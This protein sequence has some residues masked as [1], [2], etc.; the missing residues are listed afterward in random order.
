MIYV[1]DPLPL[2]YSMA[3]G[4]VLDLEIF[5]NPVEPYTVYYVGEYPPPHF[6][7][8]NYSVVE[9]DRGKPCYGLEDPRGKRWWVFKKE[10]DKASE[11]QYL[12]RARK[13][14]R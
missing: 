2:D 7:E 8:D 11:E 1:P 10:G 14:V 3:V 12:R 4:D 13:S 9:E 5:S 6:K